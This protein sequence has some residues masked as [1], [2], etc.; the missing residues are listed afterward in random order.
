[1][2]RPAQFRSALL[3]ISLHGKQNQQRER[4]RQQAN[5]Q[6]VSGAL[7][8]VI[9]SVNKSTNPLRNKPYSGINLFVQAPHKNLSERKLHKW[10]GSNMDIVSHGKTNKYDSIQTCRGLRKSS[11]GTW[12]KDEEVCLVEVFGSKS[13]D[14]KVKKTA[15]SDKPVQYECPPDFK[16]PI[17]LEDM[18][19]NAVV[20]SVGKS[21]CKACIEEN[22]AVQASQAPNNKKI[23]L[24]DSLSIISTTLTQMDLADPITKQEILDILIPNYSLRNA[25]EWTRERIGRDSAT[26]DR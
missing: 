15:S 18:M 8:Y 1:M 26:E 12:I 11:S 9:F 2:L 14:S 22:F 23:G 7:S 10:F 16:C 6:V 13:T 5:Q 24:G 17:C 20:T 3:K 19:N 25:I 4:I 21:Y